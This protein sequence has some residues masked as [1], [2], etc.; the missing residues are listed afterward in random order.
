[1]SQPHK[2]DSAAPPTGWR[3]GVAMVLIILSLGSALFVP[4]VASLDM[5]TE[6]KA[7]ISGLLVLGVPQLLMFLAVALVGKSGFDF[8][9]TRI[10]GA[11]VK[12]GPPQSVGRTRYQIGL[13]LFVLP[14]LL[15]FASPYAGELTPALDTPG[16]AVG[17][18]GDLTLLISL[19]V[20]GGDFWDKL[21]S[22]F[23]YEARAQFPAS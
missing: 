10:L 16:L 7:T 3:M 15:A 4:I 14:L 11:V 9:K 18:A 6:T 8:L 21:R 20:L 12:L 2:E 5:P 17:V 22:L 23:V 19:F 13:V 1:M